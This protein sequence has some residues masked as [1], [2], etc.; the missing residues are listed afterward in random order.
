MPKTKLKAIII[1]TVVGFLTLAFFSMPKFAATDAVRLGGNRLLSPITYL[2]GKASS[3]TKFFANT[4]NW[5]RVLSEN[6]SLKQQTE[7]LE[8][9]LSRLSEVEK[10][11]ESLRQDLDFAR[12]RQSKSKACDVIG[13]GGSVKQVLINCGKNDG[14]EEGFGVVVRGS[15]LGVVSQVGE[16][17][18]NVRML[19]NSQST[20][21][22][23]IGQQDVVGV[24]RGS[25]EQGVILDLVPAGSPLAKGDKVVTSS[26]SGK[27]ATGILVGKVGE[28]VSIPGETNLV[29]VVEPSLRVVDPTYVLVVWP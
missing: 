15:L 2:G 3:V 27:M 21:E 28:Q 9:E 12:K 14:L 5:P 22:V 7:S 13:V 18:S 4:W 25:F 10:E 29:Y 24:A 26:I 1:I 8:G 20:V 16:F 6:K 19:S 11:N 23:R 17:T